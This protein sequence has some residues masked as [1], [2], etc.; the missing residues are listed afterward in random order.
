M[1][2]LAS[3]PGLYGVLD[4]GGKGV[5]QFA[6]NRDPAEA[7]PAAVE[8]QE[9][10]AALERVQ[11]EVVAGE[12]SAPE[13]KRSSRDDAAGLWWYVLL[14]VAMLSVGELALGNRA[15]RH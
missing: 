7:D 1:G 10:I 13:G 8:P 11:G 14:A 9:I 5:F 4:K 12:E 15:T 3:G 6:V 2:V